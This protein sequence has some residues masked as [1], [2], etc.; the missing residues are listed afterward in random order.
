[1]PEIYG[2]TTGLSPSDWKA[3]ERNYRK[4]LHRIA[5][6]DRKD[7]EINLWHFLGEIYR[8]RIRNFEYAISSFVLA[9]QLRPDNVQVHEILAELYSFQGDY[10]KAVAE[11]LQLLKQLTPWPEHLLIPAAAAAGNHHLL[12]QLLRPQQGP[13]TSACSS[14]GCSNRC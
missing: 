5:G 11:H 12:Q 3:L 6:K 8:S 10:E 4:M 2:N 1:M 14:T 13:A 7:L 9:S